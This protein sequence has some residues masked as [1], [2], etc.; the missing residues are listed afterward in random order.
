MAWG[1]VTVNGY[2]RELKS[3]IP[4]VAFVQQKEL[5]FMF[6]TVRETISFAA[7]F[8]A[9]TKALNKEEDNEIIEITIKRVI[10]Q[11]GLNFCIDRLLTQISGGELRRTS[12]AVELVSNPSILFLD[13]PTS[14]LDSFT[15]FNLIKLLKNIAKQQGKTILLTIHQ[16]RF[17]IVELFDKIMLLS[18]GKMIYD[19]SIPGTRF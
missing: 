18:Q 10:T 1:K 12:V 16:P 6:L 9:K 13:E 17:D 15:S 5:F 19:G 11:L 8:R 14:G 7:R 3:W 2:E 4:L